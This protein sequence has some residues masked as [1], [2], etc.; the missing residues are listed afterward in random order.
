[1]C[2]DDFTFLNHVSHFKKS[3]IGLY[4]QRLYL[5]NWYPL[6]MFYNY[7]YLAGRMI[8]VRSQNVSTNKRLNSIELLV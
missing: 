7:D 4:Y 2:A 5:K 3:G 1:M 6:R 8:L